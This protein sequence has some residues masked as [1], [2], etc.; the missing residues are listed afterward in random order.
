[1]CGAC[2]DRVSWAWPGLGVWGGVAVDSGQWT[3]CGLGGGGLWT[4]VLCC[5]VL[6]EGN[7]QLAVVVTA[8]VVLL[9]LHGE[10]PSICLG[11]W[12]TSERRNN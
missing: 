3:V 8:V 5:A 10:G 4:A 7:G 11:S 1:M 6:E 12:T 9:H 2:A